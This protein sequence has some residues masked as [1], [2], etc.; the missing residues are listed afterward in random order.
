MKLLNR[1]DNERLAEIRAQNEKWLA[2]DPFAETW[3][4]TF[5]LRIIDRLNAE[6]TRL[7][8]K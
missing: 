6:I 2:L 3:N 1:T 7:R 5:L 4:D 8:K